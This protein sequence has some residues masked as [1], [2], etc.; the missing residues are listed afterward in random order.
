MKMVV[1]LLSLAILVL[2]TSCSTDVPLTE[3]D[4][5]S[6]ASP[7]RLP[8]SASVEAGDTRYFSGWGSRN[9]ET[10]EH[11]E[12][13]EAQAEQLMKNLKRLLES[14]RV[15]FS[16]MAHANLYIV[17]PSKLS[18]FYE[19]YVAYFPD[20]P[21]ALTTVVIPELPDTQVELTFIASNGPELKAI[22]P[23]GVGSPVSFASPGVAIGEHLYIS[24]CGGQLYQPDY[25]PDSSFSAQVRH[26]M[27]GVEAVLESADMEFADAVKAEIFVTD[28]AGSSELEDIFRSYFED[29]LPAATVAQVEALPGNADVSI[30]L[31]ASP[32]REAVGIE[33]FG[34]GFSGS[35]A[36]RAGD[37]LY[38]SGREGTAGRTI[39]DQVLSVMD[40]LGEVL[41]VGGMDFSNVVDAKV[42]LAD[43]RD[44][45]EMNRAYGSYFGDRF[46]TR[47]CIEMT[48]LPG[49]SR[50]QITLVADSRSR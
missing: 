27:A 29:S 50:V 22:L 40:E 15:A 38:L 44:Y 23:E 13:F 4:A 6:A 10:G 12:G 46:P 19:I 3:P 11:P 32:G 42:Y 49:G 25:S 24:S 48:A 47:S 17:D 41:K 45:A 31:I 2:L 39:E 37:R 30:S 18:A 16:Q 43:M 21:P 35:P 26:C 33:R 5:G 8:F 9:P 14:H 34:S 20:T 7:P 28:L 1:H 36:I